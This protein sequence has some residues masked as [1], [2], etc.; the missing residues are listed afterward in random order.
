MAIFKNA[1]CFSSIDYTNTSFNLKFKPRSIW[2]FVKQ[3]QYFPRKEKE[4]ID[5]SG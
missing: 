5:F 3:M 4:L 2:H 1:I